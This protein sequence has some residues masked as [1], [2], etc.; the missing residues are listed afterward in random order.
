M[1]NDTHE[2]L[3]IKSQPVPK[4][5]PRVRINNWQ[6]T[7]LGYSE[8]AAK[9][10]ATRCIDCPDAPCQAACPVGNDI[11]GALML[12]EKGDIVGAANVFRET[13]HLPDMCGRLCP[14]ES[15]CEGDCVV[16]FAIRPEDLQPQKP[17]ALGKLEAFAGVD[18]LMI[19][20]GET[21]SKFI[22]HRTLWVRPK[23]DGRFVVIENPDDRAFASIQWVRFERQGSA[24]KVEV[25]TVFTIDM[26]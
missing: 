19:R 14:Q 2:R 18:G 22:H 9:I 17:V 3:Q 16:G 5:D 25:H 1:S 20:I 24:V 13:N 12:L 4:Q 6:E 10:E 11:P 23:T 26:Q 7:F 8:G 21:R 15:L